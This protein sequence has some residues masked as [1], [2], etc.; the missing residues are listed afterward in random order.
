MNKINFF[1]NDVFFHTIIRAD[2]STER[3]V[4]PIVI[5]SALRLVE[6][7]LFETGSIGIHRF[8]LCRFGFKSVNESVVSVS[9][10]GLELICS[11]NSL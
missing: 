6:N 3:K 7:L 4:S 5:G 10:L 1:L 11:I 9:Q 2:T 8:N